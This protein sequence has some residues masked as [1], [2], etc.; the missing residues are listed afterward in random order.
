MVDLAKMG[1]K[2]LTEEPSTW[3]KRKFISIISQI[4]TANTSF[5]VVKAKTAARTHK[6][7]GALFGVNR[8]EISLITSS[9]INLRTL[10]RQ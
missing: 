1:K 6:L 10:W 2:E 5:F 4:P 7:N 8:N 3:G 9:N